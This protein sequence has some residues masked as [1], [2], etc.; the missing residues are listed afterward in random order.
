GRFVRRPN[1]NAQDERGKKK[2]VMLSD[3]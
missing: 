1:S 2:V 3:L